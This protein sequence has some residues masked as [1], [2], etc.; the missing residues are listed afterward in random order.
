MV[1]LSAATRRDARVDQCSIRE[2]ADGYQV[3]R[4][5]VRQA[6]ASA[7]PPSRKPPARMSPRLDPFKT[8]IDGRRCL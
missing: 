2:L 1:E 3:H 6:L 4:R 8:A 7:V 5:T